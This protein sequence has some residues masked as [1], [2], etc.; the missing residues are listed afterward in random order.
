MNFI[1]TAEPTPFKRRKRTR[2][3]EQSDS[4]DD[5]NNDGNEKDSTSGIKLFI[6]ILILI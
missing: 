4:D 2:R 1:R 6:K 3:V 5:K